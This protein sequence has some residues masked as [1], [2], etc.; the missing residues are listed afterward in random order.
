[1]GLVFVQALLGGITVI[2]RLPTP[3]STA[4]TATSLLFFLTRGLCR[5]PLAPAPPRDAPGPAAR[6]PPALAL[7]AAV[8]VYFQ[9]V[10]GGLVRHSGAALACT[11][12]PLCRG[13]LWPDAHPTVLVQALHR[14]TASRSP[15]W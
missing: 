12:I 9:M 8:A 7:V 10:L 13:S 5:R 1:M 15:C 3:V 2:L 4:H 14:L 11:D 6:R